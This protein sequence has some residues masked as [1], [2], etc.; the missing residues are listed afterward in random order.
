MSDI[1][2]QFSDEAQFLYNLLTLMIRKHHKKPIGNEVDIYTLLCHY[3]KVLSTEFGLLILEVVRR[4]KLKIQHNEKHRNQLDLE[5]G[6]Y[7]QR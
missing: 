6:T 7:E 4:L 2:L 5:R 1:R 3:I